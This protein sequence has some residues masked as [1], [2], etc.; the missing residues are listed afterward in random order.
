VKEAIAEE[1]GGQPRKAPWILSLFLAKQ[2]PV[3][4]DQ[5]L[6]ESLIILCL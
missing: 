4:V 2:A 3:H 6:P 1:L 5:I